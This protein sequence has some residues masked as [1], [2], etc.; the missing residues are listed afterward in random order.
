MPKESEPT[1]QDVLEAVH[2][3]ADIT[4]RQMVTK[5]HL[6]EQLI[7]VQH[8]LQS[9]RANMVTK[10]ALKH[11][12]GQFETRMVTKDYLDDK[13]AD[14][15][16]DLVVLNRRPDRKIEMLMDVLHTKHV[17]DDADV[18]HVTSASR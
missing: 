16:G 11:Q 18:K 5:T 1:I 12:L 7:P 17:L 3:L 14:L 10:N 4:E 6:A 2:S 15:R 13:L 8:E 9:L